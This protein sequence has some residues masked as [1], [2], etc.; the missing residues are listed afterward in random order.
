MVSPTHRVSFPNLSAFGHTHER[1]EQKQQVESEPV[2]FPTQFWKWAKLLRKTGIKETHQTWELEPSTRLPV[3]DV[4]P[5]NS[6]MGRT[7]YTDLKCQQWVINTPLGPQEG[8]RLKHLTLLT[9]PVIHNPRALGCVPAGKAFSPKARS[10]DTGIKA[11]ISHVKKA[12]RSQI[13]TLA[14]PHLLHKCLQKDKPPFQPGR[15]SGRSRAWSQLWT[16]G[17]HLLTV[18]RHSRVWMSL[19]LHDLTKNMGNS[20]PTHPLWLLCWFNW[21][22]D[23]KNLTPSLVH[24]T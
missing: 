12:Q 10:P 15:Q 5:W 7:L 4:W 3:T 22:I 23:M 13:W 8:G 17:L 16:G 21:I 11:N 18:W 2:T 20:N 9:C 6:N 1:K 14:C 19:H 24:G